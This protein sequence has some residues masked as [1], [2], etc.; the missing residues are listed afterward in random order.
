MI[1]SLGTNLPELSLAVRS[2]LSGKKDIAFGD[3][4]GSAAANTLLFGIFTILNDGEVL[5]ADNFL[6]TFLFI[7]FAVVSFYFFSRSK[8][9]ISIK[10]GFILISVYLLFIIV[11]LSK[12]IIR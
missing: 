5:T 12:Q 6:I 1:L 2:V 4:I 10:E 9:E 3:Y 8:N 11:E 7:L